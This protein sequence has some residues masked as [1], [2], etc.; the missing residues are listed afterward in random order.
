M[1]DRVRPGLR[2]GLALLLGA[3]V[4]GVPS[5]AA[6]GTLTLREAL[7]LAARNNEDV[8]IAEA[9]IERARAIRREAYSAF[10]P[11]LAVSGTYTR[12]SGEV[13]REID[14]DTVVVQAVDA[15]SGVATLDLALFDARAFPVAR[16]TT[17]Q[18]QAQVESSAEIRRALAFGVSETYFAV[19]SAER[20]RDAAQRRVQVAEATVS[21]AR[22]RLDAGLASGNELTRSELELATAQL[23]RTQAQ[24]SVRTTRLALGYLIG[25]D[26]DRPLEEPAPSP[27]EPREPEE[28]E[29]VAEERRPDLR[30]AQLRAEVARLL[31]REPLLR[32]VPTLGLRGT[33]RGTNEAGLSGNDTDWNVATTLNWSIFDGG[34]AFA[35][36][37][38]RRAEYREASLVADALRRQVGVEIRE[39]RADLDTAQAALEQAEVRARVAQQNAEEV[40]VRFGEGLATALEQADAAVSAF[41]AEAE[42]A[43]QRFALAISQLAVRRAIGSWPEEEPAEAERSRAGGP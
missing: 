24:N 26:A 41:E 13:T 30:A 9:R 32:L 1:R 25:E 21:D 10:L 33:Y 4:S 28:L 31:A 35:Q 6:E 15:L 8:G 22:I 29:R 20:L 23:A 27:V 42:L 5:R 11:D 14:G 34:A 12:R 36:R 16:S 43:R 19:L 40:R 37:A 38:A 39:A 3:W 7:D 18:L 2:W 17:R